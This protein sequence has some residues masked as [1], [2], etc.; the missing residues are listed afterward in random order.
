MVDNADP[1]LASLLT[2]EELKEMLAEMR[3][4]K[5]SEEA[6]ARAAAEAERNK[7]IERLTMPSGVS[8]AEAT[9]RIA[10]IVAR[11]VANGLKEVE[12]YRFPNQLCSDRGRAISQNEPGWEE[13]LTGV[14]K[15]IYEFW[16]RAMRPLG[17]VLRVEIVDWP[18]GMPG[19]IGM[20][21]RWA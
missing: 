16:D 14:P 11:A 1:Q 2:A 6:R 5:A 19:D 7:L 8:E 9:K 21:L 18:G 20:T 13:T 3:I 4:A 10:T 15:E 17:Y 12:I